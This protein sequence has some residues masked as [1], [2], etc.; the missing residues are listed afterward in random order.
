MN[1]TRF[2]HAEDP[3]IK[4]TIF[5]DLKVPSWPECA[6]PDGIWGSSPSDVFVVSGYGRVIRYGPLQ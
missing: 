3:S 6:P 5:Q 1:L 2:T 4:K